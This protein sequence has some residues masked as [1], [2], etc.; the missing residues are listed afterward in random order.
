[1]PGS[2]APLTF[3]G[4]AG[5]ECLDVIHDLITRLWEQ[6]PDVSETDQILFT[7][8]VLEVGNNI[9]RHGR[10]AAISVG[11]CADAEEL[12]A[13]LVDDGAAF[14]VDLE[15]ATLPDWEAE[16]GRGLAMVRIAVDEVTCQRADGLN[17][18]RLVRHRS[19][20]GGARSVEVS[21]PRRTDG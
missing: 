2:P 20:D 11:L 13:D 19:R 17:R 5:P 14:E 18:W 7:T 21:D 12:E 9:V 15:A 3:T 10:P 16:S 8:A 6:H 1:M 4:Q